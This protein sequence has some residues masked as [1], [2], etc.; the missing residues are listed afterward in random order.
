MW[1]FW[2]EHLVTF[3]LDIIAAIGAAWVFSRFY[4]RLSDWASQR[5]RNATIAKIAALEKNL[6]IFEE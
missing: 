2:Q 3:L 1:A 6:K 4:P 5:S